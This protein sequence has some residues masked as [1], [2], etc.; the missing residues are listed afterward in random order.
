M[1]FLVL[2]SGRQGQ[3]IA[4]D[5]LRNPSVSTVVLADSSPESLASARKLL[6]PRRLKTA[7]L[8]ASDL[9]RVRKLAAGSEVFISAAPY[10]FNLGLARAAIAAKTHFVDLGGN[11]GIVR[12]ELAL[13]EQAKKAGVT[14]IPDEGLGPGLTTTLA[15]HGIE[16]FEEVREVLIRDGGLPQDPVPPMNY[17]LTF[18]EEGL[19]NEYAEKATALREG[20]R[21]EV[22]GL[23]EIETLEIPPLGRLE[24]AHAAGG[25]ST[26]AWTYE[27][28]IRSMD[29]KLIRYPGH[30]SA[31]AALKAMG[32]FS[33]RKI[34]I[35]G[36][37]LSPREMTARL[38]RESF[39]RPGEKDLVVIRVT[40]RGLREG[41]RAEAV[42]T[43]LD[44]YDEKNRMTAMTRTTGFP[45]SIVAQMLAEGRISKPGAYPVETG[46]PARPFLEE[47]KKRGFNLS[48]SLRYLEPVKTPQ[49]SCCP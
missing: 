39:H 40:V 4:F 14:L 7:H 35:G 15:A 21:V 24:A 2:G 38:F 31:M 42:Y 25:L 11:T 44:R 13:H 36:L 34:G 49:A 17:L 47:L 22:D 10:F 19:I 26:L 5:L 8:D 3:A 29:C 27:G 1:K 16:Q 18:S 41:R 46:V 12:K 20:R 37:R 9:V 30:C 45:A 32:F 23:S 33:P 28:R 48:W 43:L 6:G